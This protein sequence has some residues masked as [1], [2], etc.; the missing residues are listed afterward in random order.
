[1][2]FKR[3]DIK[4]I[5]NVNKQKIIKSNKSWDI[6]N[7][8]VKIYVNGKLYAVFIKKI[9]PEHL[10]KIGREELFKYSKNKSNLRLDSAGF[11]KMFK[12]KNGD[13]PRKMA[14]PVRW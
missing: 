1:M 13:P 11:G 12:P 2:K 9:I 14:N 3:I 4:K 5:K 7:E 6:F 10:I 8:N